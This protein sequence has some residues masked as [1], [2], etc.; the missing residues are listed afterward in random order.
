MKKLLTIT[1]IIALSFVG[2]NSNAQSVEQGNVLI[3]AGYGFPNLVGSAFNLYESET[4]YHA[5]S[6]GPI[7]VKGEYMVSDRIGVGLNFAYASNKVSYDYDSFDDN[8]APVVYEEKIERNTMSI[9]GR[10]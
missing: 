6:L 9:L 5:T 4:G 8:G 7:Y 1:A 10:L 3:K 2:V